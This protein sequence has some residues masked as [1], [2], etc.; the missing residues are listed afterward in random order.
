[1]DRKNPRYLYAGCY[2]GIITEHDAVTRQERA[3]MAYPQH[4][5]SQPASALRYRFNWNA[6]IVVSV[7]DPK[8]IYHAAQVVLRSQ[9]RGSS[10]S[11]ISPDL[12]R[13]E[14]AKQGAGGVPITNEGAGAEVYNT[15]FY[16]AESPHDAGVLWAGTDDGLLHVTRDG[17]R[18][19]ANVTPPGIGEAQVNAIEVS[20][21]ES[22]TAYVAATGYR[23]NDF[24]PQ[25]LRTTDFGRTW[26]RLVAGLPEGEFVRVVREDPVRRGL[27]YAGG[28]R[29]A[30]VSFDGGA[31]W[32]SLKLNLPVVPVTDLRVHG[33]D[34]VASTQGRSF[35]ILDDLSTL[36]TLDAEAAKGPY[37]FAPSPALRL[38]D[39]GGDGG[40]GDEGPT[41]VGKNPPA[42]AILRYVLAKAPDKP[43]TL[44][45]LDAQDAVVR[46]FTSE[47]RPAPEAPGARAPKALPVKVGLNQFVWDLRV[48]G[49]TRVPGVFNSAGTSGHRVAPGR[50][51]VR[52]K[53]G[54]AVLTRDLEVRKDPRSTAGDADVAA[55]VAFQA[56]ARARVEEVH[57]A[58]IRARKVRDQVKATTA[59]VG[60]RKEA[61]AVADAGKALTEKLTAWEETVIQ[62]KQK[63][64]QDVINFRNMLNDQ[65]LYLVDLASDA[66][67]APTQGM[68]ERLAD[69]EKD[70]AERRQA[71]D[72]LLQ[73]DVPAFNAAF[74]EA[75]LGAIVVP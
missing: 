28:E 53:V 58:A 52:L 29:G 15:I 69:L 51:K 20:P 54:D 25:V 8:V 73:T 72:G 1:M 30:Y 64:F 71:L 16:L 45:I 50:Y 33:Q 18:T 68:R 22:A 13:N 21:H 2:M 66:D 62:P 32:Q 39:A 74:K 57:A 34:L 5:L 37:L 70:W 65:F 10:W 19:W 38:L 75:G 12:T 46:S 61:K 56:Q 36:R 3:V 42:G 41:F 63:T 11:S 35:W 47:A 9:D 27:L 23:R 67:A 49:V 17:G 14:K 43:I 59:L 48:E 40:P 4:G 6:P 44:D 7:H 26:T 60:D 31:L 24:T 55:L